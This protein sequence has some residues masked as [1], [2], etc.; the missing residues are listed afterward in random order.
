MSA[1]MGRDIPSA[2]LEARGIRPSFWG[3]FCKEI[4]QFV[5][6]PPALAGGE[7]QG[8]VGGARAW[9]VGTTHLTP[10]LSALKEGG[11]GETVG[12]G[13]S[14]ARQLN[15]VASIATGS[16]G[17]AGRDASLLPMVALIGRRP[18]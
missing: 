6:S 15:A 17:R 16:G 8:E 12:H 2:P 4:S 18:A 1:E 13:Q 14:A 5:P 11:E 7:G 3:R 10:A 9:S